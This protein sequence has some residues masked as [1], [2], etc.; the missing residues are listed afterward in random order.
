MA[1]CSEPPAAG[2]DASAPARDSAVD[3]AAAADGPRDPTGDAAVPESPNPCSTTFLPPSPEVAAAPLRG[4]FA[5]DPALDAMLNI[6]ASH[7]YPTEVTAVSATL[8]ADFDSD[9]RTDLLL[10]DQRDVSGSQ[11]D[12]LSRVWISL[13]RSDGALGPFAL[14]ADA[15]SCQLAA[16]LDGD[17]RVDLVCGLNRGPRAAL[18][19]GDGGFDAERST[20]LPIQD[21]TIAAATWDLDA[22]GVLD[23]AMSSFGGRSRV[24][25]GLGDR[26]FEDVTERWRVDVM[27]L[28]FQA[29][30]FDLDGDG[31][32]D[33]YFADDGNAHENRALR[34]VRGDGDAE[35]RFERFAPT[36]AACD[37]R[38]YFGRSDASPMGV[39]MA[40]LNGDGVSEI[41]LSTGPDLPL[42]AR[43]RAAPLNWVDVQEQLGLAREVTTTGS[44]LVPWSP[45]FWDFDHDGAVDLWIATGDDF[46]FSQMENRGES[47]PLIYRGGPGARF[48]ESSDALGV[49]LPG[50]F[51]HVALG[52]L[53]HDGDLDVVLG[54]WK[55]SPIALRNNVMSAG[56][57]VLV[58]LRGRVS[59]PHGLG[60]SVYVGDRAAVH[61]VG[62]RWS[63]WGTAQPVLDLTLPADA[64]G[65]RLRVRWPSGVEQ[66]VRGPFTAP[67]LTV[68]EPAWLTL[69]PASRHLVAGSTETRAVRVDLA[70]LGARADAPVEI[71]ALDPAVRWAG[72]ATRGEDGAWS[73]TLAA[74]TAP[75]SVV[76]RVR[77]DGRWMPARPRLWI[78]PP[79]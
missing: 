59:N 11:R 60:A 31:T 37:M 3:A 5:R 16:D 26:R 25:R 57:H 19:G 45:V 50:Q 38:G 2:R 27:G 77:V 67:R 48:R 41:F 75:G 13:Q 29:A 32:H 69:T 71:D 64:A 7:P 78:A 1:A 21:T 12:G 4:G 74:P 62:D 73:R 14:L 49:N 17:G 33:L 10:N 40:D 22:D 68:T 30:F 34:L 36:E 43:R 54:R 53:D 61:P 8:L 9:G 18:W 72:P 39:A 35:P 65:D 24:L 20:V 47:R 6:G 76:L 56:R 23:L 63:P 42:L 44:F 70:A 46:G 58:E 15:H 52:D 55:G 51:A 28:T 66:T 79:G